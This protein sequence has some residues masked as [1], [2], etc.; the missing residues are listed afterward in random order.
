M[1]AP[2]ISIEGVEIDALL[3]ERGIESVYSGS[4]HGAPCRIHLRVTREPVDRDRFVEQGR[5]VAGIRH[6]NVLALLGCGATDA[7]VYKIEEVPP[8]GANPFAPGERAPF[9]RVAAVAGALCSIAPRITEPVSWLRPFE[10]ERIYVRED[11]VKVALFDLAAAAEPDAVRR[12]PLLATIATI[13]YRLLSG[14]EPGSPPRPLDPQ[15]APLAVATAIDAALRG[16]PLGRPSFESLVATFAAARHHAGPVCAVCGRPIPPEKLE[17]AAH[18]KGRYVC[19]ACRG[20]RAQIPGFV[21]GDCLHEGREGTFFAARSDAGERR[22]VVVLPIPGPPSSAF[23]TN[24]A[25]ATAIR[26]PGL[27]EILHAG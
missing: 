5:A 7:C 3:S 21:L 19:A 20:P 25:K 13:L 22:I 4:R 9:E 11:G 17:S 26:G 15:T 18:R 6:P 10:L 24:A 2:N 1:T 8:A 12:R 27:V 14:E 23:E 16:D